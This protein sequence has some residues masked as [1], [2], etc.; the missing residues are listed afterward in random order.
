MWVCGGEPTVQ[1]D[2]KRG[3]MAI[4]L[5]GTGMKPEYDAWSSKISCESR[6]AICF[7][8]ALSAGAVGNEVGVVAYAGRRER[9]RN[10]KI[11]SP[12]TALVRKE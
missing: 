8:R 12:Q 3:V 9:R 4:L 5:Y 6:E 10:S 11:K 1:H 7:A 2:L